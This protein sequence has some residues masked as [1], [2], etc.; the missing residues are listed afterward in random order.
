MSSNPL[1]QISSI[2]TMLDGLTQKGS[3]ESLRLSASAREHESMTELLMS[4]NTGTGMSGA[5]KRR[6]HE[7]S[8]TFQKQR[9]KT[10]QFSF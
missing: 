2:L 4:S 9:T 7:R 1:L 6:P 5:E 3:G 8:A 10:Q